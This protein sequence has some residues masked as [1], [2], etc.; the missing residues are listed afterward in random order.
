M[1]SL[2]VFDTQFGNTE[3]VA[4]AIGKALES[5]G[6]VLV[7]SID[8]IGANDL[9]G[10]DLLVVGGPTQGHRARKPLRDW[11]DNLSPKV[12]DRVAIAA[13]D[14]RLDWPKVL[15]GSAANTIEHIVR[16]HRARLVVPPKSFI[17]SESEGP[18]AEGELAHA[19]EWAEAL[20]VKATA[21]LTRAVPVGP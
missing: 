12:L 11:V 3:K 4:R 5:S 17:V 18:L 14:T 13:F 7:T 15:S 16:H 9:D 20:A 2:V 10:V 8:E 19:V 1:T 6:P 21:M